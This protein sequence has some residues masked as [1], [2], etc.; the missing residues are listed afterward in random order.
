MMDAD[1]EIYIARLPC[2]CVVS[3]CEVWGD[4]TDALW[5]YQARGNGWTIERA[6]AEQPIVMECQEA[7]AIPGPWQR[8]T[9]F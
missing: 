4:D 2:G 8:K 9:L 7:A 6:K 5:L 1:E 3:S